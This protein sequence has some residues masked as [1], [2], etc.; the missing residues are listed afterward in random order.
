MILNT[1]IGYNL[2]YCKGYALFFIRIY[3]SFPIPISVDQV[4]QIHF[5]CTAILSYYSPDQ[6]WTLLLKRLAIPF[7]IKSSWKRV[8]FHACRCCEHVHVRHLLSIDLCLII[9]SNNFTIQKCVST[10]SFIDNKNSFRTLFC[11][12]HQWISS[13]LLAQVI[14]MIQKQMAW[15]IYLPHNQMSGFQRIKIPSE[16]DNV[17]KDSDAS[18]FV[19]MAT[20]KNFKDFSCHIISKCHTL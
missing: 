12:L 6:Q 4:Q 15:E 14:N 9:N 13:A 5:Q 7:Q 19:A 3:Q 17:I 18:A 10:Q 1:T 11:H 8:R 2:W 16:K 20:K